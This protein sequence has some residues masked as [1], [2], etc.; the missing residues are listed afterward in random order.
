[1]YF[2]P[3]T[4]GFYVPACNL[5]IYFLSKGVTKEHIKRIKTKILENNKN[6]IY[7]R[8]NK[9]EYEKICV[10]K[11]IG[12]ERIYQKG[13][14]WDIINKFKNDDID[15]ERLEAQF[16]RLEELGLEETQD[17]FSNLPFPII[18]DYYVEDDEYYVTNDGTHRTLMAMLIDAKYIHAEVHYCYK[19]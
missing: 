12:I 19:K 14:L 17:S 9:I 13:M 15:R 3:E 4:D 8:S 10:N 1:M 11:I 2:I 7:R 16:E 6:C 18:A 5:E